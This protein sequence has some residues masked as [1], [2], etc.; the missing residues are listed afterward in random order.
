MKDLGLKTWG[1]LLISACGLGLLASAFLFVTEIGSFLY[2]GEWSTTALKEIV[3]WISPTF[4]SWLDQPTHWIGLHGLIAWFF[5][6]P[7]WLILPVLALW[8]GNYGAMS[9]ERNQGTPATH[10]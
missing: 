9:L 7:S 2:T 6:L 8:I 3:L 4:V 1:W 10:L 5:K